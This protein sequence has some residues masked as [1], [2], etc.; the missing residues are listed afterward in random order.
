M[1][2]RSRP[3]LAHDRPASARALPK[4]ARDG[5]NSAEFDQRWPTL[6]SIGP[7]STDLGPKLSQVGPNWADFDQDCPG[8]DQTWPGIGKFVPRLDQT[9]ATRCGGTILAWERR[10]TNVCFV[11]VLLSLVVCARYCSL[12]FYVFTCP[13]KLLVYFEGRAPGH[14][15]RIARIRPNVRRCWSEQARLG[16][17]SDANDMFNPTA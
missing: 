8:V 14:F 17:T 16:P 12:C 6:T 9:W 4:L 1:A 10:M 3:K 13:P 5:P 7:D 2:A 11:C 15:S